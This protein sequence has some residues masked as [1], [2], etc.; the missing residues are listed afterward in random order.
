MELNGAHVFI[1]GGSRGIGAAMARAFAKEGAKVSLAARSTEAIESLASELGGHAFS[2]DLLDPV[3]VDGLI[4]RV[5]AEAGPIDVLVNNAGI[6]TT[7]WFE[8]IGRDVV[9]EVTRV[10]LE[11]PMMLTRDA[12]NGMAERGSGHIVVTSSLAGTGGFPG[13][14]VYGATKA[15]LTNFIAAL[16]MELQGS[17]IG[18]TV[19]APGPV[20][21]RMWTALEEENEMAPMLKRLNQLQI[22]P[23]KS[24]EMLAAKTV[25]AV[26]ADRRHVRVPRRLA[27][28]HWLREAP[29]RLTEALLKGVQV[30]PTRPG[31]G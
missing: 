14:A 28:N 15:G 6:E 8:E 23:K 11:V 22:I 10:N 19:V 2:A 29:T 24:P 4:A 16:R 3:V 9:R 13:L 30:G 25:K 18:T 26:K 21:T 20:D 1:T 7:E 5:E 31:Q 17:G 12:I 27:S